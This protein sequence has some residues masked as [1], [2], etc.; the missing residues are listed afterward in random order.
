MSEAKKAPQ[1]IAAVCICIGA[2]GT[3]TVIGWT[4]NITDDLKAGKLN[5]LELKTDYQLGLVGSLMTIGAMLMCIPIGPIADWIG[6]KPA[7]LLT[8]IPFSLGWLLILAAKHDAMVY[9]GR[10]FTGVGGGSFCVIAPLYTSEISQTEIRGMLGT[11][12]Q[13]F[14]TI[15][16]L[17]S[18]VF[19][20]MMPMAMYNILCLAVPIVFAVVFFFQPES[21]YYDLKRNKPDKAANSFKKLRGKDYDASAEMKEMQQQAAQVITVQAFKETMKTKQA[22]KATLICF[23]LMFYQQLSGIN[24]VMFYSKEI[25]INAGSTLPGHWCVIIIGVVQVIA[26]VIASMIIDKVGR[27][28]LLIA[29]AFLMALSLFLLGLYFMMK[30]HHMCSDSTLKSIGFVPVLSLTFFIIGFSIGMGPIPWLASSEIF[31][32]EVKAKCSSAAAVFNWFLAFLVSFSYLSISNAIGNDITF[33]IFTIITV[34]CIP[35]V[36]FVMP[37]PKGKTFQEIQEELGK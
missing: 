27:K 12:F 21:P 35:F 22:K 4:S 25:F 34:T 3:G 33:F 13:L 14:I 11:F 30:N 15:G 19:G 31:P 16:I 20:Y 6:R 26:T 32:T 36:I 17:Y 8:V 23:A 1:I 18:N 2:L 5:S 37:E 10:F 28:I 29:S 9:A 7:I 24:A